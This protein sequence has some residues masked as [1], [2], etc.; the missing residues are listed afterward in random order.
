MHRKLIYRVI[1]CLLA[2]VIFLEP[3]AVQVVRAD[4]KSDDTGLPEPTVLQEDR[5]MEPDEILTPHEYLAAML[6]IR[7]TTRD[8]VELRNWGEWQNVINNSYLVLD[9]GATDVF[10][11]YDAV[12]TAKDTKS[13]IC[14]VGD[15]VGKVAKYTHMT[16]AFLDKVSKK[17]NRSRNAFTCWTRLNN[18]TKKIADLTSGSGKSNVALTKFGK[19]TGNVFD[20]LSFCSAPKCWHDTKN[21][22]KGMDE[23]WRWLKK[24]PSTK[25][26]K[27]Q[28]ISRTIG[29][30]F[31]IVGCALSAYKLATNEDANVGRFSYNVL[32]DVVAL[33]LAVLGI[34]AMFSNPVGW[35][36]G[37]ATAVWAVLTFVGDLIGDYNKRWKNAYK[38]SYWYLYENDNEFKEYYKNRDLLTDDEKSACLVIMQ[39]NYSEYKP[40]KEYD[41]KDD[42]VEAKNARIYIALEKQGVLTSYYNTKPFELSN[43]S[44]STL[45]ELWEAKASYMAWKPTEAE[46]NEKKSFW[47]KLGHAINPKTHISWVADKVGSSK[48][49]KLMKNGNIEKVYFNPDYVLIKKYQTWITANRLIDDNNENESSFYRLIGLRLEQSPFNYIPLVGIDMAGWSKDLFQQAFVTDSFIVQQKELVAMHNQL[50]QSAKDIKDAVKEQDKFIKELDK[51]QLPHAT[52]VREFLDD[53]AK[54]F[55]DNADKENQKLFKRAKKLFNVSSL[56]KYHDPT[57]RMLI[58]VLKDQIEKA[59]LYEP[60]S[61][62]Q[63]C[64]ETVLTTLTV[65]Q[66]LDMGALMNSYVDDKDESLKSIKDDVT[67]QDLKMYI[68]EGTF[69]SVKGGGFLDWLSE[70]YSS[71]DET[72]KSLKQIRKDV[73]KYNK[74]ARI[75]ASGT[76]S[77][78]LWI[79]KDVTTP[80][81]LVEKINKEL[82]QWNKTIEAW[83]DISSDVDVKVVLADNKEFAEGVLGSYDISEFPLEALDPDSETI[84]SATLTFEATDDYASSDKATMEGAADTMTD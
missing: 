74:E 62:S 57:P 3:I 68:E 6:A 11:F 5:L 47:Q 16:V 41:D 49:N 56:T 64:A 66:Y 61:L 35:A 28:G 75:S 32:K 29:I 39:R 46:A 43:Y 54:A 24:D 22:A 33:A 42:S 27:V 44:M 14:S 83:N 40:E 72:E 10:G 52:K 69:L 71:Y 45:L 15:I 59:L 30:G 77:G 55:E 58:M 18:W 70:L 26:T 13:T 60:L 78:F 76:R 4:S 21:A 19:F 23:Y 67:N 51:N 53:L 84:A 2:F 80:P 20:G 34:I 31:A 17:L 8:E 82:E 12:K 63:K 48:Y 9:E 79:P 73:E 25:L 7:G 50:E 81:E 65:K 36:V 37:I 38:N 1:A